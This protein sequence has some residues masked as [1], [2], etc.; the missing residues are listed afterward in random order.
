MTVLLII[1]GILA[2]GLI[3]LFINK[4]PGDKYSAFVLFLI[5]MGA[6]LLLIWM[7]GGI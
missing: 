1:L 6:M 3:G 7:M 5:A 2:V 4:N